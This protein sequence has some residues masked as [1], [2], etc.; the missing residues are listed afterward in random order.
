M[1][2]NSGYW[3][4][5]GFVLLF[6]GAIAAIISSQLEAFNFMVPAGIAVAVVGGI[7]LVIMFIMSFSGGSQGL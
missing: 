6:V 5:V 2:N 7:F 3:L 4:I 1:S